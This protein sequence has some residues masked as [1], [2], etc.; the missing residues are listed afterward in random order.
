MC[1]GKYSMSSDIGNARSEL[2]TGTGFRML[3]QPQADEGRDE[4]LAEVEE[5]GD[6]I[7]GHQCSCIS[8]Q[9]CTNMT[10]ERA[11][12][13]S[14]P[15]TTCKLPVPCTSILVGLPCACKVQKCS[16][17]RTEVYHL[18]EKNTGWLI[19]SA[20]APHCSPTA[21]LSSYT[22]RCCSSC[23]GVGWSLK[24]PCRSSAA[25]PLAGVQP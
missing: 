11:R 21:P 15:D 10:S 12:L 17:T 22:A 7:P 3:Q 20:A 25:L 4:V 6:V 16:Q 9:V 18:D 19:T 8:A 24:R 14:I 5:V 2:P 23:S 1:A 13:D